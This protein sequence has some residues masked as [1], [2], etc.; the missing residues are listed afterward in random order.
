MWR[1]LMAYKVKYHEFADCHPT[2]ILLIESARWFKIIN[3]YNF[4]KALSLYDLQAFERMKISDHKLCSS[5][6]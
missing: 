5:Y 3:K 4:S 1:A 6:R 2:A